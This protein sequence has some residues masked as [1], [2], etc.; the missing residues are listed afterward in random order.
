MGFAI[1]SYESAMGVHVFPI[2]ILSPTSLPIPC[3]EVIPVHQPWA[4]WLMILQPRWVLGELPSAS[5]HAGFLLGCFP[6]VVSVTSQSLPSCSAMLRGWDELR[7]QHW[8]CQAPLFMGFSRQEYWSGLPFPPPGNL[9]DAGIK[10]ASPA[11]A[12]GFF[13][14]APLRKPHIYFMVDLCCCM[15]ETNTTL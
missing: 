8:H 2:L 10:P 14:T 13:T 11:L 3:L 1:Y 4:P 9:A 15:A 12:G 6:C 5:Y 7:E